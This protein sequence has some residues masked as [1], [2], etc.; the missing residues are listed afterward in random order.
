MCFFL[1]LYRRF[2]HAL[3]N[4]SLAKQAVQVL[5]PLRCENFDEEGMTAQGHKAQSCTYPSVPEIVK[6]AL[7]WQVFLS[8]SSKSRETFTWEL[9]LF[10]FTKAIQSPRKF[11]KF[12]VFM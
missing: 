7:L 4:I 5:P 2:L 1:T 12:F 10:L 9:Y 3:P 11:Y 6:G 8:L